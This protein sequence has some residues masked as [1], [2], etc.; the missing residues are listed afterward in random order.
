[1]SELSTKKLI[2]THVVYWISVHIANYM[3]R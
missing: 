1:M 2:K 3:D